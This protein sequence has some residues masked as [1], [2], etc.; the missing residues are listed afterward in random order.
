M[1]HDTTS[2]TGKRSTA[3]SKLRRR[4][5]KKIISTSPASEITS[6]LNSDQSLRGNLSEM[7]RM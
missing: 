2:D 5:R 1:N 4:V 3:A 7:A 6:A